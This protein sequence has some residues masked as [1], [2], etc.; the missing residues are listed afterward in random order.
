MEIYQNDIKTYLKSN[1]LDKYS[2][3]IL[4]T[5]TIQEEIVSQIQKKIENVNKKSLDGHKKKI[6]NDRLF[7]LKTSLENKFNT[8][9]VLNLVI[10]V[11]DKTNIFKM[12]KKDIKFCKDWNFSKFI[13]IQN[14]L[15]IEYFDDTPESINRFIEEFLTEEKT[16]I[17]FK[18]D[19]TSFLI[20][21]IDSTKSKTIESH[22]ISS[23]NNS[24]E[25]IKNSISKFKPTIIYGLNPIVK[26]IGSFDSTVSCIEYKNASKNEIIELIHKAEVIENQN[27]FKKTIL[28]NINN[29]SYDE[30]FLF[31]PKEVS[32]GLENYMIKKLFINPKLFKQ[33]NDNSSDLISNVDITIVQPMETGD[34]GQTLNKNYGGVVAL[35]YY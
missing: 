5:D 35:K 25:I 2:Y 9:E 6:I 7:G 34:I 8:Q 33:I 10:L 29:P 3:T 21:C 17:V 22:S 4:V 14:G 32:W 28:D 27:I 1:K 30:K 18:F 20:N 26:K 31:G 24:E 16:K 23:N 19:K 13:F 12:T 15:D 11:N